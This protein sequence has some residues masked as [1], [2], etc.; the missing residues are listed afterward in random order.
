MNW[1]KMVLI[2]LEILWNYYDIESRE[3]IETLRTMFRM[4]HDYLISYCLNLNFVFVAFQ[5]KLQHSL[6]MAFYALQHAWYIQN[7]SVTALFNMLETSS[8]C[9]NICFDQNYQPGKITLKDSVI[10]IKYLVAVS[11]G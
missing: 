5:D 7:N 11:F 9:G 8:S 4:P 1:D 6:V 3:G 10:I 2:I